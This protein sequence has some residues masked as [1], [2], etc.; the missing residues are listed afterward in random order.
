MNAVRTC[1][2]PNCGNTE[3][4]PGEFKKCS[5]CKTACYCSK[6]CQLEHWKNGH[7]KECVPVGGKEDKAAVPT[8]K[9]AEVSNDQAVLM[10]KECQT[11]YNNY[12]MA[13]TDLD[14]LNVKMEQARITL[15]KVEE[16]DA[17]KDVYCSYGS[18]YMLQDHKTTKED[19]EKHIKELS[20]KIE[21]VAKQANY[22]EKRYK[23]L[24]ANLKDM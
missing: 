9:K 7:K 22:F 20:A 14:A 8:E 6:E 12:E 10:R 15:K 19:I 18:M 5:R 2:N 11:M 3:S 1:S 23:D 17:S 16:L 4:K 24:E 13:K 21:S